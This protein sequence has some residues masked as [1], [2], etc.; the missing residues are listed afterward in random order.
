MSYQTDC[1]KG[2]GGGELK[3]LQYHTIQHSQNTIY[4]QDGIAAIT[5]PS[6]VNHCIPW[7]HTVENISERLRRAVQHTSGPHGDP[8]ASRCPRL[9]L[10]VHFAPLFRRRCRHLEPNTDT[11]VVSRLHQPSIHHGI[12]LTVRADGATVL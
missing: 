10:I 9:I 7:N 5:F 2:E 4:S 12:R 11:I 1:P 3:A 6:P 8:T